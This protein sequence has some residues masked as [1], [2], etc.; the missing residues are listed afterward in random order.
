MHSAQEILGAPLRAMILALLVLLGCSAC[1]NEIRLSDIDIAGTSQQE[2][3][4]YL[5]FQ[6]PQGVHCSGVRIR[7]DGQSRPITFMESPD[8][9]TT[10]VDSQATLP[11]DHKWEGKLR[12]AIPIDPDILERGGTLE[13]V[14]GG[15]GESRSIGIDTFPDRRSTGPDKQ[16]NSKRLLSTLCLYKSGYDFKRLFTISEFYDRDRAAFYRAIQSVREQGMDLTG[17]LGFFTEGL[18]TQLD[19]V[20]ARGER[21]IRRDL[22]AR[23]HRLS[24]RQALALGLVLDHGKL[25]IQGLE[26]ACPGVNRRSLQRDLQGMIKK[27][28]LTAEGE[29]N[30]L[31]YV[32]GKRVR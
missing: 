32:A 27:G 8:G 10:S 3:C 6:A 22:L 20:K 1:S 17:W 26:S 19:E 24:D 13:L 31:E 2:K 23:E 9:A 21:P 30:R 28:L 7:R 18:A 4:M 5:Y 11:N 15:H 29:T 25:T 12:V 16:P 14:I